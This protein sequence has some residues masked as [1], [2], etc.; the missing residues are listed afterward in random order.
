[1]TRSLLI[2]LCIAVGG[3]FGALSRDGVMALMHGVLGLPPFVA[4]AIVNVSGSLVIGIVFARMEASLNR[5]GGS[6]LA[7]LPH[8][9][10]LNDRAWWPDGDPTLPVVD[11][12]RRRTALQLASALLITGFLGAFTTFSA[13]CLLSVQLLHE[14]RIIDVL[15]SVV[16]SVS[17]GLAA[18]W[19]GV[20]IGCRITP[21]H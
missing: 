15:L 20:H 5:G 2:L 16:G 14:G 1:M 3:G 19:V 9:R 13:F 17:L 8:A 18:A 12:L 10:R 6:R 7:E 11:V 4:L 21:R